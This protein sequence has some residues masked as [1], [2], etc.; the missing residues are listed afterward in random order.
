MLLGKNEYPSPRNSLLITPEL[1]QAVDCK[2]FTIVACIDFSVFNRIAAQ[3][4][5]DHVPR[6][7]HINNSSS[8]TKQNI[9]LRASPFS[10]DKKTNGDYKKYVLDR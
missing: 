8:D 5:T 6:I 10:F 7:L 3:L 1:L 2:P 9:E 4:H